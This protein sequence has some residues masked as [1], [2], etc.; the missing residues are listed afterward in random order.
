MRTVMSSERV[1]DTLSDVEAAVERARAFL[2]R[3][4]HPSVRLLRVRQG[5]RCW[6]L[7]FADAFRDA[8]V[9]RLFLS[10]QGDILYF[11][12]EAWRPES[13]KDGGEKNV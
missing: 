6:L 8:E 9:V 11:E 4:G 3:A 1:V 2:E 13:G 5:V 12:H 7:E 10:D